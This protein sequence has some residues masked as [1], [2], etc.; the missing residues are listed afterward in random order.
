MLTLVG[1]NGMQLQ[2]PELADSSQGWESPP[3]NVVTLV[4][5][6]MTNHN[7]YTMHDGGGSSDTNRTPPPHSTAPQCTTCTLAS[8]AP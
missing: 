3:P 6:H 4:D 8:T 5:M 2:E 1:N 7:V